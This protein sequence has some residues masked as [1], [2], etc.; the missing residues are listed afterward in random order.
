MISS[1]HIYLVLKAY[2]Y[3]KTELRVTGEIYIYKFANKRGFSQMIHL[4]PHEL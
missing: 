2:V 4:L 3:E 1:E